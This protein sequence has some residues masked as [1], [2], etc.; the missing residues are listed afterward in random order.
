MKSPLFSP[1][2]WSAAAP[3]VAVLV[4]VLLVIAVLAQTGFGRS[5]DEGPIV[6]GQAD[7][8]IAYE[9][10]GIRV[11]HRQVLGNNVVAANLYL[12]G[13]N[14]QHTADNAGL[15][16]MLLQLSAYGT[17]GST[18]EQLVRRLA[19]LGTS[20][21][22]GVDSDWSVMGVRATTTTF[23]S[24]FAILAERVMSPR[25][26]AASLELI[27]AQLLSGSRQLR[28]DPDALAEYLADSITYVGHPY[29]L[30][31]AGTEHSLARIT[32]QDLLDYHRTQF[33]KSRMLLVVVGNV[34]RPQVEAMLRRTLVG[35]P[36]GAYTW[37]LPG[38]PDSVSSA[39][40]LVHRQLPTN[41]IRGYYHGPPANDREYAALRIATAVLSGQLFA[42]VRSRRNLTYA[43]EAPFVER[44]L[45]TGGIYVTAVSPDE[46]LGVIREELESLQFGEISRAGLERLVQQFLTEFFLNNE[47]NAAQAGFLA[48]AALYSGDFRRA[49]TFVDD[50]RAVRPGDVR[51]VSR[52]YMRDFRFAY[53]GDTTKVSRAM[54][55]RF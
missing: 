35:M 48:R 11:I 52:K 23:D 19:R 16:A 47:T 50:L 17:T 46:T 41:Y 42:E 22:V 37:S 2:V 31:P 34:A 18:R 32:Q 49:A 44:A 3:I 12:L 15:E 14:R 51:T 25:L 36:Q 39:A 27:R 40:V 29:G 43:V 7:S 10:D 21:E 28:D 45:A 1:R 38:A 54:L 33:V 20:V 9:V 24:S 53:V 26:E 5:V 6:P 30:S 55:G 13:G 8:T 4:I